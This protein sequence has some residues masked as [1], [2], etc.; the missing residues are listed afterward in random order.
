MLLLNIKILVI[1][2]AKVVIL[3]VFD[4]LVWFEQHPF[5]AEET[6]GK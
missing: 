1:S 2:L 6:F 5:C 4:R 3:R